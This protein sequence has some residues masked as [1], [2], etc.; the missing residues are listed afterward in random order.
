MEKGQVKESINKSFS[1]LSNLTMMQLKE[2]MNFSFKAHPKKS[3]LSLS[4]FLI[5][6]AAV[7]VICYFLINFAMRLKVFDFNGKLPTSV[8][9]VI[10]TVMFFLSLIFTT[11]SLVKSLYFSRDNF[12]LLTLP[13]TPSIVF[14]SKLLV[15]YVNEL[16][17]NALFLIP[18]FIG[19]GINAGLPIYY[20]PWMLV[21]FLLIVT[22]PVLLG[23]L[24]SIPAMYLYQA[25]KKVK[26]V[27]YS[28]ILI[29]V[30]GVIVAAAY[31]ISIIPPDINLKETWGTT[32]FQ[33]RGFLFDFESIM[34]P[35]KWL[36]ELLVGK[37]LATSMF[38][39]STLYILLGLLAT[40]VILGVLCFVLSKPLFYSMASKPF[41]YKKN[42]NARVR[43]E[44]KLSPF[45]A[46]IKKEWVLAFRDSTITTLV[47]EL[48]I[49]MPLALA[50]LNS[51][52]NAM[53]TKFLGTQLTV[54]FNLFI[55][56]LFMLSANI[57]MASAYSKDG[58]SAYLNKLQPSNYGKL[59]F[60]KLTVNLVVG[61]IGLMVGVG[62]YSLYHALTPSEY[63]MF[64]F[65]AFFLFVAHL[66]GSA[67][68]DLMNSQAQQFATFAS[69]ANNP[70]ENKSIISTFVIALLFG[71]AY[72]FLGSENSKTV[73]IKLLVVAFVYMVIKIYFYF[74]RIKVY[75]K[76]T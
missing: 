29:A 34:L 4:F 71:G 57:R 73:W 23:A 66:F 28:L 1:S 15:H 37:Y 49:I 42:M 45:L 21:M 33:I 43:K 68:Y 38:S 56:L 63:T 7:I 8:L 19:Y 26:V 74:L 25:L 9:V 62:V 52:Y 36:V 27:M 46:V 5:G 40:I 60:A 54:M 13:T 59:L 69:Q 18:L 20:Y 50:L 65:I 76:E 55:V 58:S 11:I 12:V 53:N 2:K 24:I 64:A 51:L 47:V 14:S 41:E 72:F 75:Y 3:L 6:F 39:M 30:V 61:T 35:F 10:F 44:K 32:Y 31:I 16:K 22:L 17:K 67:Q 48:L 70:N